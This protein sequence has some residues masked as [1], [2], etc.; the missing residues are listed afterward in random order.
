[1]FTEITLVYFKN[2]AKLA[3][4]QRGKMQNLLILQLV[5]RMVNTLI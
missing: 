4:T 1:M 3:E 2:Y 5:Q